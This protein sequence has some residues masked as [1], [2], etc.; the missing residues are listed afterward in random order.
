MDQETQ[1]EATPSPLEGPLA[2]ILG[3][4]SL[5][6]VF[7]SLLRVIGQNGLA[8]SSDGVYLCCVLLHADSRPLRFSHLFHHLAREFIDC[9]GVIGGI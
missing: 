1:G 4:W 2:E 8:F 6:V 9:K 3:Q 7:P 5:L